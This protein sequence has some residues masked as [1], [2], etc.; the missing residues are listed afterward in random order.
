MNIKNNKE[1][2]K[3]QTVENSVQY[4][5]SHTGLHVQKPHRPFLSRHLK[6]QPRR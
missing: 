3:K 6:D 1:Q 4:Y 5:R 2:N